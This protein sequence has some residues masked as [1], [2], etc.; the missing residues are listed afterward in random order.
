MKIC[1]TV[2]RPF[3]RATIWLRLFA[4]PLTSISVNSAPF[5]DSKLL[6]AT[7]YGQYLVV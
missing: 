4:S 3:A 5:R 2:M 6:A 7:Q 1:G